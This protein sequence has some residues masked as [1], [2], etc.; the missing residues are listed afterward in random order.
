MN[1]FLVVM[2]IGDNGAIY[3]ETIIYGDVEIRPAKSDAA[4]EEKL[5]EASA[6]ENKLII[7]TEFNSR[8][9]CI[10]TSSSIDEAV[11]DGIV[12][13]EKVLDLLSSNFVISRISLARCGFVKNLNN[14][15][16]TPLNIEPKICGNMFVMPQSTDLISLQNEFLMRQESELSKRYFNSLHW[17][18]NASNESNIQLKIIFKWFAVEALFKRNET[19]NVA[20]T[21]RWFLGY[22]NGVRAQLVQSK[23]STLQHDSRYRNWRDWIRVTLESIREFRNDST[24][25]GFRHYDYELEQLKTYNLLMTLAL[26]RCQNAVKFAVRCKVDSV[27]EFKDYLGIIFEEVFDKNDLLNNVLFSIEHEVEK[28]A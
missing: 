13:F 15:E 18:R 10:I 19:D 6:K 8:I 9:S 20:D 28:G 21:I 11:E 14:G 26:S 17:G 16:Y 25:S 24:H 27:D 23:I 2:L 4:N 7:S 22:P 1:D 3:S 5:I 12:K